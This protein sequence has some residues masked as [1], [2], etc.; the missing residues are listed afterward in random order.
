MWVATLTTV[1]AWLAHEEPTDPPR[2]VGQ[3]VD[4]VEAAGDRVRVSLIDVCDLDR[5]VD[6]LHRRVHGPLERPTP[7]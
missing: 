7:R 4:D 1:A 3:R 6:A 5:D 2:L